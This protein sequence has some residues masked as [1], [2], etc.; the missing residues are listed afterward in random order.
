MPVHLHCHSN[1]APCDISQACSYS[2]YHL[3]DRDRRHALLMVMLLAKYTPD[4]ALDPLGDEVLEMLPEGSLPMPPARPLAAAGPGA[5]D[6]ES[7]NAPSAD[8]AA[9]FS[10]LNGLPFTPDQQATVDEILVMGSGIT[11]LS[12]GPP[13][14]VAASLQVPLQQSCR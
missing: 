1:P 5:T 13:H 7:S 3:Y 12:R 8:L 11:I 2:T 9:E 14:T 10:N 4:E 6:S